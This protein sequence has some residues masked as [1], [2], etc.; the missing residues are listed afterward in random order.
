MSDWLLHKYIG[1]ISTRLERFKRKSSGLYNFRCP[2]CLDSEFSKTKAR[3]Y[4]Y[5][6]QGK[7][8]FHCHNCSA[9]MS[10]PNLIKMIDQNLYNE[11]KLEKLQNNKTVEQLDL[12]SFVEK[13][14]KPVF[15]K[16]GPLKGLKKVSQ[17]APEHPIKKLVDLRKIPT[18]YHAKTFACPDFK[19]FVNGLV[20]D[21]FPADSLARDEE[22]L[23]IPFFDKNKNLHALTGRAVGKSAVKYLMIVL[24]E[25][26]PK[27]YGLDTWDQSKTTYVLEGP[28]DSMFLPNA[29]AT[30]GGDLISTMKGFDKKNLIIIYDNEPRNKET[31]KKLD[32]AIISGYNVCIWPDNNPHK[33]INDMVLAG[34]SPDFIE[35]IIKQNTH[36]DLAAKLQ[37]QRWAKV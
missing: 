29:I 10:V 37:L 31:V 19:A 6:K 32:K 33:D 20:P 25:T 5:E 30:G 3:A 18:P 14:K 4:I 26:I 27:V 21:K 15:L 23:L 2:I 22:R 35:F 7:T 13:M 36:R 34:L 12:E 11:Y 24:D 17:L 8:F 9:T 1:I 16:E 28:I